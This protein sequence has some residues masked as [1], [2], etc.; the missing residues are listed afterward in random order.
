[1]DG[2]LHELYESPPPSASAHSGGGSPSK[3]GQGQKQPHHL[4]EEEGKS[5]STSK[6]L[7]TT[8]APASFRPPPGPL[9]LPPLP[10]DHA[11]LLH[12]RLKELSLLMGSDV[13]VFRNARHPGGVSAVFF[14]EEEGL[15]LHHCL[16]SYL[17]NVRRRAER[18]G[19][20]GGVRCMCTCIY[21]CICTSSTIPIVR[22]DLSSPHP[23]QNTHTVCYTQVF[24][25]VPE[26]ALM[27]TQKGYI[28]RCDLVRTEEIPLLRLGPEGPF[29]PSD[30]RSSSSA[31]G[32]PGA[33]PAA[34]AAPAS[35]HRCVHVHMHT[36]TH[37]HY[38]DNQRTSHT[39]EAGRS[40]IPRCWT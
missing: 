26:L 27:M 22:Y 3:T 36:H 37:M 8:L 13:Q 31:D 28:R 5:T 15:N 38:S 2:A 33:A 9:Q 6:S 40:S 12:F 24:A 39:H 7:T 16:D 32:G 17:E 25:A 1:M 29:L 21:V 10:R 23:H 20:K 30:P 19:G 4:A 35:S 18:E 14:E 34:S 11:H